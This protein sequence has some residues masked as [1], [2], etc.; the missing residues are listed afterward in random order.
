MLRGAAAIHYTTAGEQRLAEAALGIG[1][2]V[3]IPLGVDEALLTTPKVPGQFRQHY[4]SLARAP[5]VLILSR[6]H[7]KKAVDVFAEVFLDVTRRPEFGHWRLVIAGDG[8]A[9]YVAALKRLVQQRGGGDRVLFTGWLS[10]AEKV[11][12]IQD[13]ALLA[14]ASHQE[15]F[16]IAVVEALACGVPVLISRSVNLADEIEAAGSGWVAPLERE[17]LARTLA[18]A[19]REDDERA[20]RGAAG[21]AQALAS[22]TWPPVAAELVRLYCSVAQQTRPAGP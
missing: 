21:R 18:E 5:Y 4:P 2:G 1:R 19:I 7:P 20:R 9:R 16:G 22:F 8:E 17:A 14:L 11:G 3:V 6:L 10:G 12:A 13:A 15:N